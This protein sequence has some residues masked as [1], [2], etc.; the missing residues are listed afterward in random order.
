MAGPAGT[1]PLGAFKEVRVALGRDL[2]VAL[3]LPL[4]ERRAPY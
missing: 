2:A 4:E 3:N 1:F